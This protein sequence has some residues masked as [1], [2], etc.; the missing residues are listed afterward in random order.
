LAAVNVRHGRAAGFTS[1]LL[2][3]R[4]AV[5]LGLAP[6]TSDVTFA[7]S[8]ALTRVPSLLAGAMADRYGIGRSAVWPGFA[9]PAIVHVRPLLPTFRP[10]SRASIALGLREEHPA[11]RP[12]PSSSLTRDRRRDLSL[13]A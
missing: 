5:R 12:V 9:H 6:G 1:L 4:L 2:P 8:A 10:A 3:Y 13:S 11:S 7:G